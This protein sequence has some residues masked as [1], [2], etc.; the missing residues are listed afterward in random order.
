MSSSST[1][2]QPMLGDR[3]PMLSGHDASEDA[4][5]LHLA[6]AAALSAHQ[7][8]APADRADMHAD[9]I[10]DLD[11]A[12]AY[13]QMLGGFATTDPVPE[14]LPTFHSHNPLE[15]FQSSGVLLPLESFEPL[16]PLAPLE[17][18][19]S[20]HHEPH[21][22]AAPVA[23]AAPLLPARNATKRGFVDFLE[24]PD[25][26]PG[27]YDLGEA[28]PSSD[29]NRATRRPA[30][31]ASAIFP[32]SVIPGKQDTSRPIVIPAAIVGD[33]DDAA[34]QPTATDPGLKNPFT[35]FTSL[36]QW[37]LRRVVVTRGVINGLIKM[38]AGPR[39]INE[40][41]DAVGGDKDK[42]NGNDND[43]DNDNW[44]RAKRQAAS[45]GQRH[46]GAQR[47]DMPIAVKRPERLLPT[48]Q[49]FGRGYTL[50]RIDQVLLAFYFKAFCG[51]RTLLPKSNAWHHS[52]GPLIT[53]AG[54]RH[55]L[56]AFASTYILDYQKSPRMR[57]RAEFHYQ[58]AA[59][60]L[61]QSLTAAGEADEAKIKAMVG[62]IILLNAHDVS[63]SF[64]S[65]S[66]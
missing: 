20:G 47:R 63:S 23:N 7:G 9:S 14:F 48:P 13:W 24:T 41:D 53:N 34:S 43:N 54:A 40:D 5:Q 37:H 64:S 15:S 35:D 19:E 42:D 2:K 12:A 21:N 55:S 52:I 49:D 61:G 62:S 39:N 59:G 17:S 46:L 18:S 11:N 6:M 65:P 66:A 26:N 29:S 16:E 30:P 10:A 25:E 31:V 32:P 51:G 45:L 3:L 33:G 50:D 8:I 60:F 44:H 28:A 38:H 27:L 4:E 1:D 22:R 36:S 56:F 57:Q 58:Q